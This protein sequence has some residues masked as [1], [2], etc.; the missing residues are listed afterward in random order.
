MKLIK[1][2]YIIATVLVY[3][4]VQSSAADA[5]ALPPGL[6]GTS[7]PELPPGLG[8][9]ER[10]ATEGEVDAPAFDIQFVIENFDTYGYLDLRGG[11]RMQSDRNQSDDILGEM[12]LQL[13]AERQWDMAEFEVVADF[14]WDFSSARRGSVDLEDGTGWLDLRQANISFTPARSVDMKIGRQILTW[15]TGDLLFINDNF[16]KD[17]QAF[18]SGRDVEYLKAP[19]DA[20]RAAFFTD[21]ANLDIVYTPRFDSD[22][23]ISGRRI[24]YYSPALGRRAGEDDQIDVLKPDRWF[25]DDEIAAR[26]YR[27]VASVELALYGYTGYWKSPGGQNMDGQAIF[28]RLNVWGASARAPFAGGIGRL[29]AG[30]YDSRDDSDGTNPLINNS[31]W[32]ALA[33]YERDLAF[34]ARDFHLGVQYYVELMDDYSNYRESLPTGM[35]PRDEDRHVLTLRLTKLL[36]QQNL[37]LSLFAYYSPSDEDGYARPYMSYQ[38]DDN[39]QVYAGANIF[40]G[41]EEHTFFGQFEKNTNAYGG[42]RYSF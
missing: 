32:R 22:R 31:E 38:V 1:A 14:M 12:R 25:D 39:W 2:G 11:T 9:E 16:P 18:F 26:L 10:P 41:R 6:G 7:S 4:L 36:M 17:W 19:S 24:S 21:A 15:G 34:I 5:P 3:L 13:G 37:E 40:A 28:P 27:T 8:G 20:L 42:L 30:Y 23:Y 29:E 35:P 33:G